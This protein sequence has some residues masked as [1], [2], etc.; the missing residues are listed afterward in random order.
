M[1]ALSIAFISIIGL[2]LLYLINPND[3]F[4][5]R[6]T[7]QDKIAIKTSIDRDSEKIIEILKD[8]PPEAK[9]WHI[10]MLM[11]KF[12]ECDRELIN[13]KSS[14]Y[15]FFGFTSRFISVSLS[16]VF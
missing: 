15:R 10:E 11:D 1:I 3:I 6:K 4:K 9:S 16:R 8:Q 5:L 12:S 14:L 13:S 7:I 2:F